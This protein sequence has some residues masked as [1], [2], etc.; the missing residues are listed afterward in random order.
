MTLL[1]RN[2]LTS[3]IFAPVNFVSPHPSFPGATIAVPSLPPCLLDV[4]WFASPVS[5]GLPPAPTLT[6]PIVVRVGG[7]WD[8][9]TALLRP[10]EAITV[11]SSAYAIDID[12]KPKCRDR[13]RRRRRRRR[14]DDDDNDDADSGGGGALE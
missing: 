7:T 1:E 5:A 12:F 3:Q 14:R 11:T 2:R 9:Y 4:H 8:R 10:R 6:N 13:F